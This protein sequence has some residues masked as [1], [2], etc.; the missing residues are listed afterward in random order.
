MCRAQSKLSQLQQLQQKTE[1]QLLDAQMFS[2]SLESELDDED[3]AGIVL[4]HSSSTFN[5]LCYCD[6]DFYRSFSASHNI[7]LCFRMP[8]FLLFDA[9]VIL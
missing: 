1:M 2:A 4:F 9:S 6:R 8:Q 3:A 5:L 7:S